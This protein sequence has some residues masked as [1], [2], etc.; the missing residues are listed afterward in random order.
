MRQSKMLMTYLAACSLALITTGCSTVKSTIGME[1]NPNRMV[2]IEE[3]D[4]K[5]NIIRN[6]EMTFEPLFAM[7]LRGHY[8]L[9]GP[10]ADHLI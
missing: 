9:L 6:F 7:L 8:K 5:L 1:G 3:F 2:E 10:F 4:I